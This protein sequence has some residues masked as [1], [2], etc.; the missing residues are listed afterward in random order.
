EDPPPPPLGAPHP[1]SLPTL[2]AMTQYEAV[3]LFITRAMAAKPDFL[4]TNEN[5]PAVAAIT[6]RLDG[7][8]LAIELAAPRVKLLTPQAM[9]PRLESRLALLGSGGSRD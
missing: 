5:A 6:A 9:L 4:V 3:A 2:E 7:L 8:P 1:P